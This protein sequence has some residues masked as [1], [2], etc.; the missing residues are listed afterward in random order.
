MPAKNTGQ[1][2]MIHAV[3]VCV[4]FALTGAVVLFGVRPVLAQRQVEQETLSR[5]A[6]LRDDVGRLRSQAAS[7]EQTRSEIIDRVGESR[8]QLEPVDALNER[9][10]GLTLALEEAG[11]LVEGIAPEPAQMHAR[12]ASIRIRISGRGGY[13]AAARALAHIQ[14]RFSDIHLDAASIRAGDGRSSEAGTFELVC[15]W[16]ADPAGRG[17]GAGREI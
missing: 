13:S 17:A 11:L 10:G 7:L 2:Y 14:E 3:G 12:Y 16:I 6:A 15:V 4:L 8:F 1:S 9:L 5:A